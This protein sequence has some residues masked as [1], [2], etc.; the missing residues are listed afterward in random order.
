MDAS[1]EC[2]EF[3]VFYFHSSL[4]NIFYKFFS[5]KKKI[6]ID[7]AS[8]LTLLSIIITYHLSLNKDI[9]RQIKNLI[10]NIFSLLKT[11]L[12]LN[13]KKIQIFFLSPLYF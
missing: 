1:N 5:E 11:N 10:I 8:N 4:Q 2:A 7:S 9:L 6:I 13:V 12:Y 3:F